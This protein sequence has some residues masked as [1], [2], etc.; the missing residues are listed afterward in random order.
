MYD[1]EYDIKK[2]K[3]SDESRAVSASFSNS[4]ISD[5]FQTEFSQIRFL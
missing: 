1:K 2:Q 3:R 4:Q 5:R